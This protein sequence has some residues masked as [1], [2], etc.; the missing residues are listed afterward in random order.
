MLGTGYRLTYQ[1]FF[2]KL[3]PRAQAGVLDSDITAIGVLVL[4]VIAHQMHH[5]FSQIDDADRLVHIQHEDITAFRHRSRLNHE[6]SCFLDC[7]EVAGNLRMRHRYWATR[8][9]LTPE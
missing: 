3:F 9:D 4:D 7:H 8:A 5:L 1:Q 6:L 2:V